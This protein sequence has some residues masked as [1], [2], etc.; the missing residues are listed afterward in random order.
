M[1]FILALCL[2][3]FSVCIKAQTTLE[4]LQETMRLFEKG[5]Y[6]KAIPVAEKA[7]EAV[8]K[9]FGEKHSLYNGTIFFL[10]VCHY[11]LYHYEK[12]EQYFVLQ[13]DLLSKT[14]GE[15]DKTYTACLINLAAVYRDMGKYQ[16]S[17]AL[18]IQANTI[19]KAILGENDPDY[20]TSL[21]NLASLYQFIGQY[22]KAEQL[23]TQSGNNLKRILG[24]NNA[25]YAT[26]LNNMAT[27]Y[28][29]MG[30]YEKA[31]PIL[32][33]VLELRKSVL[34]ETHRDYGLSL[35]NLAALYGNMGQYDKAEPLY[36]EGIGILKKTKGE[37]HPDYAS[38]LDN[39]AQLYQHIGR[40][41]KAERL[42]VEAGEIRVKTLGSTHPDIASTLN[43]IAGLYTESG[44][45]EK[46][47]PIYI[48]ASEL[49]KKSF[50]EMHP[51]YAGSLNNLGNLYESMGQYK[52]AEPLYLESINIKKKIFGETHISYATGLNNLAF[53]YFNL[54]QYEKAEPLFSKAMAIVKN[55]IG[56]D[57]P[58]YATHLNN[59]ANVWQS[60][61]QYAKA[62]QA[63]I[64]TNQIRE[65]IF[66]INHTDYA[67]S[68]NNLASLYTVMGQYKK[69]EPLIIQAKDIWR[70]VK[71]ENSPAYATGL[72]NVAAFYR[73]TQTHYAQSETFYL[74]AIRLR[75]MLLGE[76]HP[77]YSESQNDLALLYTQMGQYQKAEPLLLS[78][79]RILLQNIAGTFSILSE[80]EKA[81]YLD[82]NREIVECNNSFLYNNP[83]A[84][85]AILEN[86]YNLEL[87][88]KSLSLADTRNMLESVRN[89]KDTAVKRIFTQWMTSK[90]ILAKQYTLATTSQT[91]DLKAME[92]GAETLEK[93][94]NRRSAVFS[95]QQKSL[96]VTMKD[97]QQNLEEDEAAI[98]FTR[99][100]LYNKKWTDSVIYGAYIL[101]KGD[102]APRFVPLCEKK[103]LQLLFDSAGNTAPKLVKNFYRG[104]EI[105]GS[106]AQLGNQLYQLIWQPLEPF[107]KGIKKIAYSPAGKLYSVAFHALPVDSTTILMDKY[108]LQQY[109][110]TRQISLRT[111][112]QTTV[113]PGSI[114]LFGDAQ[115]TMDSLQL[116]Q[117]R[118][119][120]SNTELS[121]TINSVFKNRGSENGAWVNL[122]GTAEEIK[123]IGRLFEQNKISTRLFIQ[124][125]A[126]E[127]NLKTMTGNAQQ[128]IHIA[129]HGFFLPE[130]KK[131]KTDSGQANAYSL[132]EDPLLRSGLVLA[133][134]N[135]AWSGKTPVDGVED[136]IVT[137]YEISQLNL[138][139]TELL[140]LS[141]CETALGDVKGTEGVFGLQRGF[142][143]AGVKKMIVSLWQVPDKETAELMTSFY[144]YWMKGKTIAGAFYQA[145]AE[146]R[147]K[148][149]AYY[150]A[151]FVL[152]E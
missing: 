100:K 41:E 28:S 150:W 8:K 29:V 38:M 55:A 58:D 53:L 30:L 39:L 70:K 139:N 40:Y 15:K 116:V 18:Y 50:G 127:G 87:G 146:M 59:I 86:N 107:L 61:E 21:N 79:S 23:F 46:A 11:K 48:F 133:G 65:K 54:G 111:E 63:Y 149:P 82:Y 1:K 68:L 144:T 117:Q 128:I 147:Q 49:L 71:G 72:N 124:Q 56:E 118:K 114:V 69:A 17:E 99:F 34:G 27:L 121:T 145:Q 126:S 77:Y 134:G 19:N 13:K 2:L 36:L 7:A 105:R 85:A 44:Q 52:K 89:N 88:F 64:R 151:A 37:N 43:N 20:S 123:K 98:E 10:A 74:E 4:L 92:A 83:K 26:S 137:A 67:S 66:G 130:A 33:R 60:M 132:A 96:Q 115:F 47:E 90:N 138:S 45:Y 95:N 129:T 104:L 16:Q 75:K 106:A 140:V 93:E 84:S 113:R 57:N 14:S 142:K 112:S 5:E 122:P 73:K 125:S 101:R 32:I 131:K 120:K 51:D 81:K 76:K 25:L 6:E 9:D 102:V 103:Q 109:T 110:S 42:F 119:N 80:K 12:A 35:N 94:L 78:S 136:G 62:E 135:Y 152:V 97:V 22:A 3:F 143:M 108:Q 148:Y 141:A 24:E 31:K 91:A